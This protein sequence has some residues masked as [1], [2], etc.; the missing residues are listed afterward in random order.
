MLVMLRG[1][2]VMMEGSVRVQAKR[3]VNVVDVQL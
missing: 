1:K 3:L 2:K